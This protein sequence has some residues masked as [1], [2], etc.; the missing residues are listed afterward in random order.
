MHRRCS[1]FIR[2]AQEQLLAQVIEVNFRARHGMSVCLACV[3]VCV[4]H[5]TDGLSPT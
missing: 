3:C 5:C 1:P 4:L 2:A